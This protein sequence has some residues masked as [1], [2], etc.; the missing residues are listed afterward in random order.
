MS[1]DYPLVVLRLMEYCTSLFLS[2]CMQRSKM[3][4]RRQILI[5]QDDRGKFN[6]REI[7]PSS[8]PVP[9]HSYYRIAKFVQVKGSF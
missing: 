3:Q 1:P 8:S 2:N 7:D 4:A 9:L 5:D 6:L